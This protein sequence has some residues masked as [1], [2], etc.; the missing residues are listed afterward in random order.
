MEFMPFAAL[1]DRAFLELFPKSGDLAYDEDG[2]W[3]YFNGDWLLTGPS[4]DGISYEE[5]GFLE[6]Y[7]QDQDDQD[8]DNEAQLND[9]LH[10]GYETYG[11]DGPPAPLLPAPLLPAPLLPD[12]LDYDRYDYDDPR[13]A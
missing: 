4:V 5:Y 10:F 12:P 13:D 1:N 7:P 2:E 8:Q 6:D 3:I 11:Q 9:A